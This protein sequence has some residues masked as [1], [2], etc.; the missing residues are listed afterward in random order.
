MQ[1]P[2]PRE[3]LRELMAE[4]V[5]KNLQISDGKDL[6]IDIVFSGGL[7]A[8]TMKQSGT[9]AHLYVSV[10]VLVQP[11]PELYETGVALASFPFQRM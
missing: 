10:Q 8:E 7:E 1:P 11:R 6:L 2:M 5:G 4:I 3:R 9:G